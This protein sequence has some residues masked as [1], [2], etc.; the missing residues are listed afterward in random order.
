VKAD[1]VVGDALRAQE[2]MARYAAERACGARGCSVTGRCPR[3][4]RQVDWGND[5]H[6]DGH[7]AVLEAR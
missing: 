5:V 1:A 2:F 4:D 3:R 7:V 6:V